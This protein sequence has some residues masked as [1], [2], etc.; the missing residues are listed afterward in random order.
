MLKQCLILVSISLLSL[1]ASGAHVGFQQFQLYKDTSRPLN[2][3]VWYPTTQDNPA[4]TIAENIAF[5][6][7]QVIKNASIQSSKTRL[8]VLSHGYRGNW[9]N[10]N[11][12]ATRLAHNGYVVAAVD[13]PGTTTF[14]PSPDLAK[15]WWLRPNDLTRLI[16][17]MTEHSP[18]SHTLGSN[19]VAAIGHSLGGWSVMQLAGAEIDIAAF[20]TFCAE[21]PSNTQRTCGLSAELGLD[22]F[23]N[24]ELKSENISDARVTHVVSL[25]LGLARS[26]SSQSLSRIKTQTLIIAAGIDIGDLPQEVESGYLADQIPTGYRHYLVFDEAMHF[27]FIQECKSNAIAILNEEVPGDGIIC[28]DGKD[29]TRNAIHN[30]AARETLA[31][32][33]Q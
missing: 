1:N 16:D 13:H 33:N 24:T 25:D 17:F 29:T 5:V 23:L 7:T 20:D 27:S 26:F 9:K 6:G 12:L 21:N 10:L 30:K 18:W 15:Q 32:L 11:W 19:N 8:I 2:T 14:D 4:E 31:F 3:S 28:K 22:K